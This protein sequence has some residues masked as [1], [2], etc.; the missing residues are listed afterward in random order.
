MRKALKGQRTL[1]LMIVPVMVLFA[2]FCYVPMAGIVIAFRKMDFSSGLFGSEWVGLRYFVQ[3]FQDPYFVRLLRNTVVLNLYMML[4][5]FPL[6]IVFAL[7]VNEIAHKKF[8]RVVQSIS[9]LPHF[10]STV[11][12][13]GIMVEMFSSQGV[14]NQVLPGD[15]ILFFN[16][17]SWFRAL[18]VGSSV[19]EG[20][21]W[22]SIIY[23]SALAGINMELYEAAEMDGA[24]RWQRMRHVTLPGIMPTI[25]ILFIL[26][27]GSM[28]NVGFEKV[29]L[30]Y[31]PGTYETADV[32]S[33]YVY[34]RG[35]LGMDYS[36]A[37]AVN[38]FNSAVN[39]CLLLAVNRAA[40]KTGQGL[41]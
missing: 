31:N 12:I 24:N 2:I 29:F 34:R 30:M 4:F 6:P 5:T 7:L 15:P 39:L 3:F 27:I 40:R 9:Y 11:V 23:L 38:L 32:I 10:I 28:M 33:T 25:I 41:W 14:I 8:K 19:W 20:L 18:Y 35:I 17:A 16:E 36:Y 22:S 37:A 26:Q 21:G 13:V 1:L